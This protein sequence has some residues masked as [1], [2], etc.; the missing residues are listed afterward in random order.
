[1]G[2]ILVSD[3]GVGSVMFGVDKAIVARLLYSHSPFWCMAWALVM[4][5]WLFVCADT[6]LVALWRDNDHD[7][8]TRLE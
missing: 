7:S 1:M 3:P 5:T 4:S 6:F 2:G 8:Q